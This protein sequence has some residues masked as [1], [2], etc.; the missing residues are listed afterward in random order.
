MKMNTIRKVRRDEVLTLLVFND[1]VALAAQVPEKSIFKS[2][3]GDATRLRILSI[4]EGGLGSV[5]ELHELEGCGSNSRSFS[6]AVRSPENIVITAA[7]SMAPLTS[8]S[9]RAQRTAALAGP[10]L[11]SFHQLVRAIQMTRSGAKEV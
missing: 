4:Y 11:E 8:L 1:I 10:G 5:E 7:Y 6:M 2:R 9:R 3:K